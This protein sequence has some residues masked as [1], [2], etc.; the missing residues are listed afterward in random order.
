MNIDTLK[1]IARE[2]GRIVKEGYASHHKG[3]SHKGV[4]DLVTEFDLKTEAFILDQLKKAFPEHT[5][6]GEES[7]HGI[8]HYDKA[9][10]ID[11]IDGTTNFV[12]GIPHL[13]ISLGVWEQGRPTLAV[14]YNPILEELF[15]AVHGE[16]A[17]CNGQRLEVSLQSELQNA[18][19]A[20]GFPYTKVNAGIE[21][22]W[23]IKCMTNLL[24]HI[25]DIRRLGAAAI[26]LCY[27]A[28]GK[29][30]AFYEIDLKPW[31]VAAGILI[32]QEAG[33]KISNVD[34]QP[35]DFDDKSIVA[36]NGKVHQ[37]LIHYLEKI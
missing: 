23:V 30:E 28:Q 14:V 1:Q 15:W 27:L 37:Q 16:G 32:V 25:Q 5:L 12:H 35:F 24:P 2:A 3:V 11:P 18:L 6:V 29:V 22:Q 31:D 7:H 26:D 21:Y 9:I 13:A 33:G 19:I 4:V 10:Y 36:S 17:Y 8:Y 20:T 34:N